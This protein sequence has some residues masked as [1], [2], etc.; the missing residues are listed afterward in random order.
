MRSNVLSGLDITVV[1]PCDVFY[2]GN[3]KLGNSE[4]LRGNPVFI[5]EVPKIAVD[6]CN[7]NYKLVSL[8]RPKHDLRLINLTAKNIK[9]LL[10]LIPEDQ[11]INMNIANKVFRKFAKTKK[12]LKMYNEEHIGFQGTKH[13]VSA[14]SVLRDMPWKNLMRQTNKWG[15]QALYSRAFGLYQPPPLFIGRNNTIKRAST[16]Q[17]DALLFHY[18]IIFLREQLNIDG[19]YS[20]VAKFGVGRGNFSSGTVLNELIVHNNDIVRDKNAE[21]QFLGK[22]KEICNSLQPIING[23][24]VNKPAYTT[25]NKVRTP[26]QVNT[27]PKSVNSVSSFKSCSSNFNNKENKKLNSMLVKNMRKLAT[28]YKIKGRS[29]LDKQQLKNALLNHRKS[30]RKK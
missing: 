4:Q 22:Q 20:N 12:N 16:Y 25:A 2:H 29:K 17:A 7:K 15:R 21:I 13:K 27:S 19:I 30:L 26:T 23:I 8:W 1:S 5:T 18:L 10:A 9:L 14:R 24:N 3:K 6:Y 28:E 11:K